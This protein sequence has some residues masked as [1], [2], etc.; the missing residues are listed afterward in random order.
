MN[1]L[2]TSVL[3]GPI[4]RFTNSLIEQTQ[5]SLFQTS[6]RLGHVQFFVIKLEC[7]I[8]GFQQ[9]DIEY[10]ST[11]IDSEIKLENMSLT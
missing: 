6:N 3:F 2:R 11:H 1:W 5:T 7:P 9:T 4:A 10:G 8:F